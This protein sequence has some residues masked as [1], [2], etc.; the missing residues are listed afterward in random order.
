MSIYE[1]HRFWRPEKVQPARPEV[2]FVPDGSA[3]FAVFHE[4]RFHPRDRRHEWCRFDAAAL[5]LLSFPFCA[6]LCYFCGCNMMVTHER[7]RINEYN[8]YLKKEI[9]LLRPMIAE[10]RKATQMHWGG[11]TPSYL[12]PDEIPGYRHLYHYSFDLTSRYR[13]E[14]RSILVT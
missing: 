12:S 6:K 2:H 1:D 7:G 8:E 3:V 11:G 10:T 9:D 14:L 13:G 4:R 5:A